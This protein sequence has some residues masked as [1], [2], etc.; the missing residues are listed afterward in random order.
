ML[1]FLLCAFHQCGVLDAKPAKGASTWASVKSRLIVTPRDLASQ[2]SLRGRPSFESEQIYY[3][4]KNFV[5]I[6]SLIAAANAMTVCRAFAG[7]RRGPAHSDPRHDA[8]SGFAEDAAILRP[9]A[10]RL[11]EDHGRD[12]RRLPGTRP[13]GERVMPF[14]IEVRWQS[15]EGVSRTGLLSRSYRGG[16]A[17]PRP[18]L[19]IPPT[20]NSR[21]SM[22]R[23]LKLS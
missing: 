18:S 2:R 11:L 16:W 6:E 12:V 17:V 1:H 9:S 13:R 4:E 20:A 3:I 8:R 23:M 21:W 15:P 22:F 14:K 7:G 19:S 10:K 5:S